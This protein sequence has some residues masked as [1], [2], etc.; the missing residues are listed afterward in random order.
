M[1]VTS[2]LAS[3]LPNSDVA[4]AMDNNGGGGRAETAAEGAPREERAGDRGKMP[5]PL[6]LGIKVTL[7]FNA[8]A[9]QWP[10]IMERHMITAT[11]AADTSWNIIQHY[12][13]EKD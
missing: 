3:T 1:S 12:L 7:G 6:L 13:E 2:S 4:D 10:C 5:E 11:T 8:K 9:A